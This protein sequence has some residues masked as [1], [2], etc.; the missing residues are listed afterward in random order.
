MLTRM[1]AR[2]QGADDLAHLPDVRV[3]IP[4]GLAR[5]LAGPDRHQRELVGPDF[6]G[7]GEQ[8]RT[9]IALDIELDPVTARSASSSLICRTSSNVM[10][11][12]SARG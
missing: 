1:S 5:D 4:T 9:R 12:A 10:C 8:V 3:R 2:R 6:G 11:R 7:Q